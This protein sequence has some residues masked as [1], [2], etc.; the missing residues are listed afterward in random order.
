MRWHDCLSDKVPVNEEI[1]QVA[2]STQTVRKDGSIQF[3]L[4][5][6]NFRDK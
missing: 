3:D 2:H 5:G 6:Q 4:L 1:G